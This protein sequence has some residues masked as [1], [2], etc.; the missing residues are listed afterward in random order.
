MRIYAGLVAA[1]RRR[2]RMR[3]GPVSSGTNTRER[4][5]TAPIVV[6]RQTS[7][8]LTE[9]EAMSWRADRRLT[10]VP[11][12]QGDGEFLRWRLPHEE[13]LSPRSG[14]GRGRGSG[15]RA[16]AARNC[17]S[18]KYSEKLPYIGNFRDGFRAPDSF[19]LLFF[20]FLIWNYFAMHH[21]LIS[22]TL[23]NISGTRFPVQEGKPIRFQFP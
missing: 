14:R 5:E 8:P 22:R 10:G 18:E 3:P 7:I 20:Y 23:L 13:H 6:R 19:N 12:T 21:I 11:N 16:N 2:S 15:K 4:R 17:R 9:A 1:R